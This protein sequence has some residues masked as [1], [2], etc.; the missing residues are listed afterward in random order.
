MAQK[1][2]D[3]T[4]PEHWVK[5]HILGIRMNNTKKTQRKQDPIEIY[6]LQHNINVYKYFCS[7]NLYKNMS[8]LLLILLI[9]NFVHMQVIYG[10]KL[11]GKYHFHITVT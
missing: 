4:D 11:D 2:M 1:H 6:F 5:S 9:D 7:T 8:V 10:N 3:P